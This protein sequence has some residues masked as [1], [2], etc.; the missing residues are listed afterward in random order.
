MTFHSRASKYQ[1]GTAVQEGPFQGTQI[2]NGWKTTAVPV[3]LSGQY[4]TI[5]IWVVTSQVIGLEM[6]WFWARLRIASTC[7]SMFFSDD[8]PARLNYKRVLLFI[9]WFSFSPYY[10]NTSHWFPLCAWSFNIAI[11]NDPFVADFNWFPYETSHMLH[12]AGIFTY[13]TGWFCSGKCW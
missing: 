8:F 9:V 7:F 12:G 11:E 3:S 5:V 4:I 1:E 13:I 2:V 6:P 10:W